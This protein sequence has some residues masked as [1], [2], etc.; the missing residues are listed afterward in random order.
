MLERESD[1]GEK[2]KIDRQESD[3]YGGRDFF[4]TKRGRETIFSE[5]RHTELYSCKVILD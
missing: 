1:V 4:N 2:V 5:V 3:D